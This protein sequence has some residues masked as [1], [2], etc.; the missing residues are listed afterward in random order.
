MEQAR[1]AR[2]EMLRTHRLVALAKPGGSTRPILIGT[3]WAKVL[4]HLLLR[5]ARPALQP[6]LEQKQFGVGAP[7]GGLMMLHH[8][9]AHLKAHPD[10]VIMQLDFRNAFGTLRREACIAQLAAT[11]GGMP[12]W[13]GVTSRVLT[14]PV[15]VANPLG[16]PPM[17]TYDGIPQGDPLSTLIFAA[18]MTLAIKGALG[19]GTAVHNVSYIDDT[20][21]LGHADEVAEAHDR[22]AA[23]CGLPG[24]NCN[25]R[26]PRFGLPTWN[27]SWRTRGWR[28]WRGKTPVGAGY[29]S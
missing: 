12:A 20:L 6:H 11:L 21:L 8:I 7:Q 22:L 19:D 1:P 4:S 5:E 15:V 29:L 26:R 13:L 9:Q 27:R 2:L 17:H 24:W 25:P 23:G 14:Q 10:H 28:T 3:I 16:G 18:A